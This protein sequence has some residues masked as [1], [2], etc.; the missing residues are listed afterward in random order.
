MQYK[1]DREYSAYGDR[2]AYRIL[3]ENQKKRDH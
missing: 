3:V 2:D 1:M